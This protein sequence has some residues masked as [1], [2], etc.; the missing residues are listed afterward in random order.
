MIELCCLMLFVACAVGPELILDKSPTQFQGLIRLLVWIIALLMALLLVTAVFRTPAGLLAF[1]HQYFG[2]L[3][4]VLAAI[5]AGLETGVLAR[6]QFRGRP[7]RSFSWISL[8]FLMLA[9]CL[10]SGRVGYLGASHLVTPLSPDNQLRFDVL[11]RTFVPGLAALIVVA[12]LWSLERAASK[13]RATEKPQVEPR[14]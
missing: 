2:H 13:R 10:V 4:E 9:C 3:L 12:W 8:Y 1:L 11:H 5:A 14:L 7:F 6:H